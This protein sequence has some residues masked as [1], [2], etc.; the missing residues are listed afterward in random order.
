MY[1]DMIQFIPVDED[2]NWP[3]INVKDGTFVYKEDLE[4]GNFPQ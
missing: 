2:Q 4:N 3:R 1:L